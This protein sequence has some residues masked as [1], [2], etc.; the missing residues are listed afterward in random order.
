MALCYRR[1][2]VVRANNTNNYAEAGMRILKDNL[3]KR[4]E[5]WA[6][7]YRRDTVVRANN[8]NNYAEAGMRI[9]K[10]NLHKW[11]E[12]WAL[13]YRR[14]TVVRANNMNNYAEEVMRILKDN[15]FNGTKA[16]NL[17]QLIDFLVNRLPAFYERKLTDVANNMLAQHSLNSRFYPSHHMITSND[18]VKVIKYNYY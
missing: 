1:D 8:T 6:L 3:H 10:D 14:D 7:C 18:I 16:Y 12:E 4:K 2:T 5:E 15:I 9:L 17:C 11:K 13:C